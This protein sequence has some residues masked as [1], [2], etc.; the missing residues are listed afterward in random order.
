MN[1]NTL[2]PN[3]NE[4]GKHKSY[5]NSP[6]VLHTAS[7]VLCPDFSRAKIVDQKQVPIPRVKITCMSMWAVQ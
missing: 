3:F 5:S 6:K 7:P 1:T 4:T 2:P